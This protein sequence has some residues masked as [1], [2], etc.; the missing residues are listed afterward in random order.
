MTTLLAWVD[1]LPPEHPARRDDP[2]GALPLGPGPFAVA[3]VDPPLWLAAWRAGASVWWMAAGSRGWLS[4]GAVP[5]PRPT[6]PRGAALLW[7]RPEGVLVF[8]HRA[9]WAAIEGT[10]ALGAAGRAAG[11]LGFVCGAAAW[12]DGHAFGAGPPLYADPAV[13]GA[14][15]DGARR[16]ASADKLLG[17]YRRLAPDHAWDP[18]TWITADGD[19]VKS[20]RL[21]DG[22]WRD[23][24]VVPARFPGGCWKPSTGGLGDIEGT[25]RTQRTQRTEEENA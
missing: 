6:A 24:V 16:W 20:A 15:T 1:A 12:L 11:P 5:M 19:G 22:W 9:L 2:G 13:P 14:V 7:P 25:Q 21:F 18:A 3:R 23:G 17:A 10:A 8:S 4:A